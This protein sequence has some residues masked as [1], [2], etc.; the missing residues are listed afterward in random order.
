MRVPVDPATL[1]VGANTLRLVCDYHED[2]PGLEIVYLLGNFGTQV[3]DTDIAITPAPTD[4]KLGDW[5]KQGLAFYGGS[6][7]YRCKINPK[8][9]GKQRLFVQLDRY[10]GTAVAVHVNGVRAGVTAWAPHEVEIT[11]L[12]DGGPAELAIEVLG[13]RRNSHGPLHVKTMPHW[14]GPG[15][16]VDL[17]DNWSDAYNLARTGL[18]A[19]PKLIVRR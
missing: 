18:M 2:H 14:V 5:T 6:A 16:F 12:L 11:D 9:T 10:L 19:P 3:R 4:L 7:S 17:E 13:S 1:R 8:L 15:A